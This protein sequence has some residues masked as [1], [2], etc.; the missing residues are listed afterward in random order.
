VAG[1][2][3]VNTAVKKFRPLPDDFLR[4]S[5]KEPFKA[6][7]GW[8]T[9]ALV[10]FPAAFATVAIVTGLCSLGGVNQVD[11]QGTT[12]AV[13]PMLDAGDSVNVLALVLV[14]AVMAPLVEEYLFRGFVL[15]SLTR[16]V[17]APA[18]TVL[19]AALFAAAHFAPK[20]S[21]PGP[22]LTFP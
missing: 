15:T 5:L 12:D 14:T 8:G 22:T 13:V 7:N 1:L 11:G 17:P 6:P 20:V 9:W 4:L 21:L 3:V 16:Y 19:S 2:W 18:A 10:G